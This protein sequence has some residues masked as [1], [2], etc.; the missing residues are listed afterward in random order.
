[1][2]IRAAGGRRFRG[3]SI[4]ELL[5]VL[6]AMMILAGAGYKASRCVV[7]HLTSSRMGMELAGLDRAMLDFAARF[8]DFP[9]DFHDTIATW[10]FLKGRFPQCPQQKYPDMCG[11]SPA[12]ALYFWLAGPEG[13]GFSAD[14]KDPFGEGKTRIGPFYKFAPDRLKKVDG[15]VQYFPPRGIDGSPGKDKLLM[16]H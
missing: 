3:I 12:T 8:G 11:Q 15:L 1:M 5:L 10:R 13:R 4:V 2:R 16:P 7:D 6:M 14:P 9:P